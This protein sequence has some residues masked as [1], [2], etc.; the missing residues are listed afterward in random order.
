MCLIA[1]VACTNW[2]KLLAY[3]GKAYKTLYPNGD[4]EDGEYIHDKKLLMK[5]GLKNLDTYD[6][7]QRMY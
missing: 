3:T 4:K 7:G 1:K 6:M 2:K 5:Y